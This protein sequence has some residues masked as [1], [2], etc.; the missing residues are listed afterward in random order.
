MN[1]IIEYASLKNSIGKSSYILVDVRSPGEFQK[2]TIPGA[3]NIPLFNNEEREEIGTIYVNESVDKAKKLGVKVASS[4]LP[5]IYEKIQSLN[6]EYKKIVFFCERGGMRSSCLVSFLLSMGINAYKIKGGY[7]GYRGFINENLPE[8][9]GNVKFIVIHGNTGVGKTKI[10]KLLSEKGIDVLDLEGCANNRGSLFGDI[11]L[12]KENSQK[13]FESLV[14]HSLEKRK[15]NIVFIEAESKRIGHIL[16]PEF[17]YKSMINGEHINITASISSRVC[18]IMEDYVKD[19]D[20]ELIEHIVKLGKYI[21][22]KNIELFSEEI[23][24][25]NYEKVIE[26]LM[27]KYYDPM[28]QNKEYNYSFT[29]DSTDITIACSNIIN[30]MEEKS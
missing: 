19:N 5:F 9:I 15:G 6:K 23:V 22:A 26:D 10:L 14:F 27:I 11:G 18:N 29:A 20:K 2:A 21:S 25:G 13:M 16:L 7:K 3:I 24:K 4:K 17:L 8:I 30:W 28:Y 12:G 1:K